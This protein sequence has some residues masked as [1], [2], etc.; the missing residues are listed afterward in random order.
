MPHVRKLSGHEIWE[1]RV[2]Q[3]SDICRLFYFYHAQMGYIITSGYLKKTGRTSTR[4]IE[5]A[6]QLR[7]QFLK[8]EKT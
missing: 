4:E 8:E 3:G 7:I 6:D 5:K 1:I 2:G